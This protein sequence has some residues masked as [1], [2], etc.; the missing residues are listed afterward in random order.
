MTPEGFRKIALGLPEAREGSHMGHTD[1]RVG[2]HIFATLGYPDASFGMVKLTAAQQAQ[3]VK[4]QPKVLAPVPGGWGRR[5]STQVRLRAAAAKTLQPA[6]LAAWANV[7]PR[8]LTARSAPAISPTLRRAYARYLEI[9]L[10]LPGTSES[11]SYGTPSVKAMGKILSRWR[12][13]AEGGLAI[14]CDF[15]DRQIMLQANPDAFFLTDHY[16]N[17][18]M[19]LVR[20]ERVDTDTLTDVVERAWRMVAPAKLLREAHAAA[21]SSR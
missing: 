7:A 9:A 2:K 19:I 14:R 3:F 8:R 10:R 4:Q 11:T 13:E 17:Y 5:G 6:L 20:L 16:L 21:R 12:T 1:F 18:P 15:L